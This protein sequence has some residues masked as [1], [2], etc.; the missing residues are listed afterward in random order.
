MAEEDEKK[1]GFMHYL[2]I[3]STSVAT[4][5]GGVH[6]YRYNNDVEASFTVNE[7]VEIL[8]QLREVR[9]DLD[10]IKLHM[11]LSNA[12]QSLKSAIFSY[13]DRPPLACYDSKLKYKIGG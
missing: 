13:Q 12:A 7:K 6:A 1:W 8:L 2:A 3:I 10:A 4:I 11:R 5:L 9:R